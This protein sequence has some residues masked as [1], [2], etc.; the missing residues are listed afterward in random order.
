LP[1]LVCWAPRW[2]AIVAI[3]ISRNAWFLAGF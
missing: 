1:A 3:T 2:L